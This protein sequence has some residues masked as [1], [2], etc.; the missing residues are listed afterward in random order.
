MITAKQIIV[1]GKVQGVNFRYHTRR[2]AQKLGLFGTVENLPDGRVMLRAEGKLADVDNLVEWCRK[3]PDSA[4]VEGIEVSDCLVR[5]Y[6][7]FSIHR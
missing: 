5:G 3:G 2:Q 7:E 6:K 1:K 4:R